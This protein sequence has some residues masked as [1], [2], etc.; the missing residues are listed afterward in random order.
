MQNLDP[1]R[2]SMAKAANVIFEIDLTQQ[3]GLLVKV[4]V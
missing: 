2:V 4:K 3:F 1:F